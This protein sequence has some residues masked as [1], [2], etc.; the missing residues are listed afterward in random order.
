MNK[1]KINV[2]DSTLESPSVYDTASRKEIAFKQ[3]QINTSLGRIPE[4]PYEGTLSNGSLST[5]QEMRAYKEFVKA[6]AS[7]RKAPVSFKTWLNCHCWYAFILNPSG[8]NPN[9]VAARRESSSINIQ[10]TFEKDDSIDYN[11]FTLVVV[12]MERSEM[13]INGL[14]QVIK[15]V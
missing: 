7:D 6:L 11:D 8:S 13:V 4:Q 3:L 5:A 14:R 2:G 10:A 9:Y 12:S 15:A 1:S